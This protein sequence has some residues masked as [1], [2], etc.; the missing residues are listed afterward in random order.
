VVNRFRLRGLVFLGVRCGVDPATLGAGA[1]SAPDL[2]HAP[3][4]CPRG[5]KFFHGRRGW[6]R[7]G[8]FPADLQLLLAGAIIGA[9]VA[10]ESR[11]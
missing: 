9:L 10:P 7:T 4:L 6:H 8:R 3:F 5:R 1:S 11:V 2:E